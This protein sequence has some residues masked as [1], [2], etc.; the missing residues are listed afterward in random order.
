[1]KHHNDFNRKNKLEKAVELMKGENKP[2]EGEEAEESD[3]QYSLYEG[4]EGSAKHHVSRDES[5]KN[6]YFD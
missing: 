5:F 4:S 6:E 1:M 3:K 2:L